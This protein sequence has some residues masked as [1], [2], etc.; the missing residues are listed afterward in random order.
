M[1]SEVENIGQENIT[2]MQKLN[3][4]YTSTY[5]TEQDNFQHQYESDM[6]LV[7]KKLTA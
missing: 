5:N 3:K 4:N 2:N 1:T 7:L 6:L